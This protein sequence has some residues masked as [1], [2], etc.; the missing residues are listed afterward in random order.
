MDGIQHGNQRKWGSQEWFSYLLES[1]GQD[2]SSAYF[3]LNGYHRHR[4][5]QIRSFLRRAG[6]PESREA[7]LDIGCGTGH[8]AEIIRRRFG[9]QHAIGMDFVPELLGRVREQFP[10]MA[11]IAG[12]LPELAFAGET[13]DLVIAAEVL[14][15]LDDERREAALDEIRRVLKPGGMFLFSSALG[16]RYFTARSAADF[17]SSR[18][19][20]VRTNYSYNR[21]YHS[22]V[23]RLT[24]ARRLN[25]IVNER[26]EPGTM[27]SQ[28][29]LESWRWLTDNGGFRTMLR[30]VSALSEP[31][32]RSRSLPKVMDRIGCVVP[33][34]T[35]TNVTIIARKES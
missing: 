14:Y 3:A 2:D 15:Y 17:V 5:R 28:R 18:F 26:C 9:F 29:R 16:G 22:T 33:A 10:G 1:Q 11:F 31:I 25:H 35:R 6:L 19:R 27:E 4:H 30:G 24:L 32:L 21:L 20:I 12:S 13:F 8:M 7:M 34:L 23:G